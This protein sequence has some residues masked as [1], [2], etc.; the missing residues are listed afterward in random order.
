MLYVI[1]TFLYTKFEV[2]TAVQ[3]DLGSVTALCRTLRGGYQS[4][5]KIPGIHNQRLSQ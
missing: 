3:T 2:L 5:A 1:S 4:S